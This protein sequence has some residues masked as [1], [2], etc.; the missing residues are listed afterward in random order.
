MC[1]LSLGSAPTFVILIVSLLA[2]A[3]AGGLWGAFVGYVKAYF[4]ANEFLVSMMSTYVAIAVLDYLLRSPLQ[5]SQHEYPQTNVLPSHAWIPT[6]ISHTGLHWGFILALLVALLAYIILWRTS[7]GYR[8]RAVGLNKDAAGYGGINAKKIFVVV[9]LLS[10]AFAGIAGFT[11]VNGVQHML[12]Q[13]LD[14]TIGSEGIA[15]AIL[16][17][18]NPL[19]IVL[20]AILFGA[21][22]VGGTQLVQTSTIPSSIIS[23][24][25]GFVMLFVIL[26]YYAQDMIIAIRRKR[27][28][29]REGGTA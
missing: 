5:Q 9:F 6:L 10:G 8:I 4:N 3:L 14:P 26:S 12:V 29:R 21:L 28:T 11:E 13:G 19:G 18:A 20:A 24:I 17:N 25:E 16:G 2:S 27:A 23:I 15:I 22:K 1:S 7:L